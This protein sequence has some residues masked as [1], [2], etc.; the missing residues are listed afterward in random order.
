MNNIQLT[1]D[2]F[3]SL[4]QAETYFMQMRGGYLRNPSQSLLNLM[5]DIYRNK[6]PSDIIAHNCGDCTAKVVQKLGQLY[7]EY[8][9]NNSND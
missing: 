1:N 3:E 4:K 5:Y 7:Y 8:K 9:E 6:Y 2:E